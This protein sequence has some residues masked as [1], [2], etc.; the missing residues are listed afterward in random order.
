[1]APCCYAVQGELSIGNLGQQS[2]DQ[3]WNSPSAEDL[4]RGM[5]SGDVPALCATC[6]YIDPLPPQAGLKFVEE[7]DRRLA[8]DAQT[9]RAIAEVLSL[10]GAAHA[11][12]L[13]TAPSLGF[14]PP[15]AKPETVWL[16][17]SFG[18]L[19]EDLFLV[20]VQPELMDDGTFRF[21]FPAEVWD[22]L[23][24]NSGIWWNVWVQTGEPADPVWR[25]PESWCF[26]RHQPLPR[27][28]GSTLRYADQNLLPVC[29]LGGAKEPGFADAHV[30]PVRPEVEVR[31]W[32][33]AGDGPDRVG[34]PTE[35]S[36]PGLLSR[37]VTLSGPRRKPVGS[38]QVEG[39]IDQ[40]ARFQDSIRIDG[41]LL[42]ANQPAVAF[43]VTGKDGAVAKPVPCHRPDIENA[44]PAIRNAGQCGFA[45]TLRADRFANSVGYLFRLRATNTRCQSHEVDVFCPHPTTAGS[46]V[47]GPWK[48]T[49]ASHLSLE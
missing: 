7:I 40:V 1:V 29:D 27:I 16:G 44:Y 33:V 36:R 42:I 18:G 30:L 23:P 6:R 14:T 10:A 34:L 17:A 41:W 24:V 4:R 37:L 48:I 47:N 20:E 8:A 49:A 9:P 39:F 12:R 28:A 43:E 13:N 26:I 5:M 25:S 19:T 31:R 32:R 38:V 45:V 22:R 35:P 2:F 15:L 3:I 21:A 11:S 46:P